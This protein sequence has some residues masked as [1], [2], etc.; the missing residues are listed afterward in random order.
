[1]DPSAS[2]TVGPIIFPFT[3][4]TV[5]GSHISTFH[6]ARSLML[7]HRIRCIVIAPAASS[8]ARQASEMGLEVQ[9]TADAPAKSRKP[10]SD[11]I[12]LRRRM[13]ALRLF[14]PRTVVHCNDLWTLE[15]WGLAG[16]LLSLPVVYHHRVILTMSRLDRV[17]IR[18]AQAV[19]TI[20]EPCRRNLGVLADHRIHFVLNPF[21]APT[22]E[23]PTG[24]RAE[25]GARW[26]EDRQLVLIGFVGNFQFRKR[27]DFFLEVC[28]VL[29]KREPHARFIIFGRER[30]YR[31]KDLEDRARALGIADKVALAGFRSPTEMNLATL[32]I[33]LAPALGEPFGRTLVEALLLGVPFVATDDGGHSEIVARWSGGYL[34]RPD[35][36]AE[37]FADA[38]VKV[39]AVS[40]DV[41][42]PLES[43]HKVAEELAPR[44]HAAKILG[45]YRQIYTA[46]Q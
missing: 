33:L 45:I 29:A 1:M 35:A 17:L 37:Q 16:R 3:G 15:S 21:P 40:E 26:H 8:I 7:D 12:R 46:S 32:D 28:Q 43:R 18:L 13:Q 10:W 6:L 9:A 34:V 27:P 23:R 42:L 22:L 4:A 20:S 24:W 11:L 44:L 36:T 14:G 19:I 2:A 25:F 41:A 31:S 39:L 38:A 30:D 5:G